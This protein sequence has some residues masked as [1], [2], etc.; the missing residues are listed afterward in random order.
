MSEKSIFIEILAEMNDKQELSLAGHHIRKGKGM[1]IFDKRSVS[2][3]E[4]LKIVSDL[5]RLTYMQAQVARNALC[6]YQLPNC[7]R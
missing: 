2:L 7:G 3:A 1:Y 4:C 6:F 5:Y